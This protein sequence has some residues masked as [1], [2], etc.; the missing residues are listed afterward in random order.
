MTLDRPWLAPVLLAIIVVLAAIFTWHEYE[1]WPIGDDGQRCAGMVEDWGG[2]FSMRAKLEPVKFRAKIKDFRQYR[3]DNLFFT[4]ATE[5]NDIKQLEKSVRVNLESS[6]ESRRQ[7]YNYVIT[8]DCQIIV[9]TWTTEVDNS[10]FLLALPACPGG[11]GEVD[12]PV[13]NEGTMVNFFQENLGEQ[14]PNIVGTVND[15]DRRSP[16]WQKGDE[17]VDGVPDNREDSI[18]DALSKHFMLAQVQKENASIESFDEATWPDTKVAYAGE[19]LIDPQDCTFLLN[20]GSGTYLPEREDAPKVT[21]F[22]AKKLNDG[23]QILSGI[24]P[25]C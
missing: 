11:K 20:G 6:R 12:L 3:T 21:A 24:G 5:L 25:W 19:I 23:S 9:A 4:H 10:S 8:P 2:T 7:Q 17:L 18:L 14:F 22:F 13:G 15:R 1:W 16:C